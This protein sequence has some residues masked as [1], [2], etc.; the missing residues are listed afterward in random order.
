MN[1][2]SV[3]MVLGEY[4]LIL[5]KEI[6]ENGIEPWWNLNY[7]KRTYGNYRRTKI[8]FEKKIGLIKRFMHEIGLH[9]R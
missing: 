9:I 1:I 4:T 2:F 7:S 6:V 8:P 3:K 5:R